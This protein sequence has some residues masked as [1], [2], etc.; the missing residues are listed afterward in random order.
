MSFA[1]NDEGIRTSKTV[2]GTTT[3]YYVNGGLVYAEKTDN[4]TIVYIYDYYGL[5]IGM[6]YRTTSYAE[7]V[8][9]VFWFERNLQGNIV[10]VYNASGT[11]LVSYRYNAWGVCSTTY[12]NEGSSTGAAYNPFRYRGYYYDTDLDMYYLQSRY[13]DPNNCR[14]ISPD[15]TSYLG[16]NGDLVSYNLYAYCSNNPVNYIDPSGKS[17]ISIITACI[18]ITAAI[19]TFIAI[20]D[21]VA[22]EDQVVLDLSLSSYGDKYGL[23]LLLDFDEANIELY[24]HIGKYVGY[25]EGFTYEVGKVEN[26]TGPHSYEGPFFFYGGGCFWGYDRCLNPLDPINGASAKSISFS[27]SPSF[28]YGF[29]FYLPAIS[30]NY[31]EMRFN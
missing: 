31:E 23:S 28:Y 1:Y 20:C 25:C 10:A 5:P 16:A 29:D 11:K 30:F 7:G 13:Y 8:W 21:G 22:N 27:T 19:T 12:H 18:I 14:F 9:D 2:N 3:T 24:P 6:L 17:I 4:R 15:D 26:Y